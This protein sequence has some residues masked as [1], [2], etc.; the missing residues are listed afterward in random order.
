MADDNKILLKIQIE[1]GGSTV[2]LKNFENQV[3]KSGVAIKDLNNSI[4]NFTTSRLKMDGQVKVTTD[5]FKR[6]EK[7][8]GGFKTAAGASTSATLEL[9]RVL[10]DMPYGIRGVANN[11]QQ[12]A[13]NLF[14]MSKATDAAT[15]KS[16]GLT[17]A[18]W[19]LLKGLIGPA[20]ILIAFQGVIA[21]LDYFK[22]GM[23]SASSSASDFKGDLDNLVNTLDNLYISQAN[24]NDKILEYI[25]YRALAKK[26]DEELKELTEELADL[27]EDI[28]DKR[29]INSEFELLFSKKMKGITIEQYKAL[30]EQEKLEARRIAQWG[31]LT[32]RLGDYEQR[33]I[34]VS[35][36][37]TTRLE[38]YNKNISVI[39]KLKEE[40]DKLSAAEKDSLK[41]L[42]NTVIELKKERELRSKSPEDYKRLSIEIQEFQD[43]IDKIEA[44]NKGKRER[45][46][47]LITPDGIKKQV[48]L[49]KSLIKAVARVMGVEIG[50]NP[51]DLNK[52]IDV[53]LSD[54]TKALIKKY[55][56]DLKA[57]MALSDQLG[58]AQDFIS[59]SQDILGGM[60]NFMNAQFEREMTIESN[61]TSAL[62]EELNNR[63]LNENLS[64]D[65]RVKIQNQ[66]AINDEKLRKK[67]EKIAKKQFDMNKASN[68]ASALMDT[69]AAAIGVMKDA[70][71]GFFARLSQALP[72][73]AFGLAQVATISR[74]KFQTS[75]AKTPIRTTAD[76]GAGG[77]TS[78]RA[79]PSFNIVG[80]SNDNLLINAIQAQFGKPLKAYVVSRDVTTQQQLDG[81]IVGQAGT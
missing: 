37:E 5:Q 48:K 73:I 76:G 41:G 49:G 17:G 67:Q 64:K 55:N 57:E 10:S 24:T 40:Q 59:K 33:A 81:M 39:R 20:G 69:S 68:I 3:I 26:S 65:E 56:E 21:L 14:F 12:L 60:T 6:L 25:E 8:V 47:T 72:T 11:L 22:V 80:R 62:N 23:D 51:I 28:A 2:T 43:K 38:T 31:N 42:K 58:D 4:G 15:G 44:K 7:S 71:G 78:E 45:V 77:A 1:K 75:A 61:K 19:N 9:G 27:D 29:R 18:V 34:K 13:S 74:Q 36:L 53:E 30:S 79:E 16:V 66:I 52:L 46:T 54:E 32:K 70:K 50:K 35:E 63:L